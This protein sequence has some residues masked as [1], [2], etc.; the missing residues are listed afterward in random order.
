MTSALEMRKSLGN[1]MQKGSFID[2][3]KHHDKDD[4]V[5]AFAR[6]LDGKTALVI[7]NLNK[8]RRSTA[9]IDVPGI[10]ETQ[11][12]KNLVKNY[13]EKSYIQV[14]DN[15]VKVDLGPSRAHVYMIDTPNIEN[16]R[17]GHVY[18][19]NFTKDIDPKNPPA[20]GTKGE[21]LSLKQ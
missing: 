19:Q 21:H 18:T 6:H 10:K 1:L 9:E 13:G 11:P 3:A 12:M 8:N 20:E 17:K 4:Q 7:V 14:E 15:K 16:D 2:L 5:L